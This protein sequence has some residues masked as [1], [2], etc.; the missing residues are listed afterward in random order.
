MT[1]DEKLD[2]FMKRIGIELSPFQKEIIKKIADENKIYMCYPPH[3][4]RYESLRLIV[5][6]CDHKRMEALGCLPSPEPSKAAEIRIDGMSL[7]SDLYKSLGK[8]LSSALA[9]GYLKGENHD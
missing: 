5:D 2:E 9:C 1:K 7:S 8:Q 6:S 4:G 3:V